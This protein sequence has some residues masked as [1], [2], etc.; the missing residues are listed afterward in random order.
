MED[1]MKR[2][3]LLIASLYSLNVL[4]ME[5]N[6]QKNEN[7]SSLTNDIKFWTNRFAEHL[8]Y[9]K[10]SGVG[11]NNWNDKLLQETKEFNKQ[12]ESGKPVNLS[13]YNKYL[14]DLKRYK[15]E[16]LS[17]AKSVALYDLVKH[18]LEELKYHT[19][20][21]NGKKRTA[22]E[23]SNFWHMHDKEVNQLKAL[24]SKKAQELVSALEKLG[25]K[26]HEQHED[27]YA[28]KRMEE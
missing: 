6:K 26:Q 17:L 8:E 9:L 2:I 15:E 19:E 11:N 28:A 12:V 10:A 23:E 7:S 14:S 1:Y 18:M 27:D 16:V 24:K 13:D 21:V 4:A 22:K 20:N 25:I 3:I 5:V